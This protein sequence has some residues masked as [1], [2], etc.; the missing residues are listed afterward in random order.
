[1][2]FIIIELNQILKVK[3]K[4]LELT[5]IVDVSTMR[6]FLNVITK[7]NSSFPLYNIKNHYYCYFLFYFFLNK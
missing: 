5:N 3:I 6:I 7:Y 1:M 4:R 2:Q